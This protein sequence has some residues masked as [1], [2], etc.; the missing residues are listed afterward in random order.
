MKRKAM[1]LP[2]HR[3]FVI[4]ALCLTVL[5]GCT[6]SQLWFGATVT[7]TLTPSPSPTPTPALPLI[8]AALAPVVGKH[9]VPQAGEYDELKPG[10]HRVVLLDGSGVLHAW[11]SELPGE[12]LPSALGEAELVVIL[13]E[14]VVAIDS[15]FYT[16][17]SGSG[18]TYQV[19]RY[20]YEMP[21]QIRNAQTGRVVEETTLKGSE[22]GPYPLTMRAGQTRISGS[23]VDKEDLIVWVGQFVWRQ[24]LKGHTRWIVNATFSPDS[25]LLATGAFDGSLRL[26][27]VA[28]GALL[29]TVQEDDPYLSSTRAPGQIT[30]SPDGQLLAWTYENTTRMRDLSNSKTLY[31][32]D[33]CSSPVFSPDGQMFATQ[34]SDHSIDLRR[35]SDGEVLVTF[36]GHTEYVSS[37][38][39]L[40]D[41]QMLASYSNDGTVRL[42]RVSDGALRQLIDIGNKEPYCYENYNEVEFSPNG[43]ELAIGSFDMWNNI[44]E[45]VRI[46]DV[47]LNALYT[48]PDVHRWR[49][50][51]AFSPDGDILAAAGGDVRLWRVSDF[52]LLQTLEGDRSSSEVAFSP[53]GQYLADENGNLWRVADGKLLATFTVSGS[54]YPTWVQ[55]SP[56]GQYLVLMGKYKSLIQLIRIQKILEAIED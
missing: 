1:L 5:A 2:R 55:I 25:Q 9:G 28:N 4:I 52:G 17:A 34:G 18:S 46:W 43:R 6:P 16:S 29:L 45:N 19:T 8:A 32:L 56:D 54:Y 39:F 51:V 22:P 48:L 41:G 15:Q 26:W 13:E 42:W 14:Q 49:V 21:V 20:R 12:W 53:D 44:N 23:R 47:E 33:D 37:M 38:D 35:V 7:P 24:V 3:S 30:F 11:N 50:A 40:P 10:P 31:S 27:L 36:K